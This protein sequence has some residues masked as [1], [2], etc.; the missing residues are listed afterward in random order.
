MP[1]KNLNICKYTPVR[2][3][4]EYGVNARFNY[5][6]EEVCALKTTPYILPIASAIILG[7]VK[8]GSGLTI[9]ST[10]VLSTTGGG[11]ASGT[12]LYSIT[13][14]NFEADGITYL[15][16]LLTSD[17]SI[18]WNDVNRYIYLADSEW[19]YVTGGIR[20]LIPGFNANLVAYNLEVFKKNVIG[21]ATQ[22][23]SITSSNFQGN[24]TTYLNNS[25]ILDNTSIYL[26]N[27]NRFIYRNQGEWQ[28]VPGGINITLAGFNASTTSYNLEIFRK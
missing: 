20:I 4:D 14:S 1:Y 7:G 21:G 26:N 12:L 24:G 23:I 15:N 2:L 28:Y 18:F 11:T 13:S 8:V 22:Q 16:P 27:L 10:G 25:L 5:L 3:C 17:T 19:S 9:D 6:F